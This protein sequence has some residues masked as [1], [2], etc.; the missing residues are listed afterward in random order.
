MMHQALLMIKL[1]NKQ[2]MF[3]P[4]WDVFVT[5]PNP[6]L[7]GLMLLCFANQCCE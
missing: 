5:T 2:G 1:A 7:L 3:Q 4:S 6:K